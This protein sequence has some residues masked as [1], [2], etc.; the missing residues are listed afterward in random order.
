[1]FRF[2]IFFLAQNCVFHERGNYV[3]DHGDGNNGGNL[4]PSL[5][6]RRHREGGA[7]LPYRHPVHAD[8]H[9]GGHRAHA[10]LSHSQNRKPRFCR[11]HRRNQ[12][13]HRRS[14]SLHG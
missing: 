12:P 2:L 5:G 1:M 6:G 9:P 14:W 7:H 8:D 4:G 13:H 3:R 10:Q 11:P